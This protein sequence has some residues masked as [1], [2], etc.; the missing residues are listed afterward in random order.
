MKKD[1]NHK[2]NPLTTASSI[3]AWYLMETNTV[4]VMR[5]PVSS[6]ARN[7]LSEDVPLEG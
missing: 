5:G 4:E 7:L 6:S 3:G 2:S 1:S